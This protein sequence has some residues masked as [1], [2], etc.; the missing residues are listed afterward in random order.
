MNLGFLSR[1][2]LSRVSLGILI[3]SEICECPSPDAPDDMT[4]GMCFKRLGIPVTHSPL[5]H[6]VS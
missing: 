6:Q 1:M 2:V 4:L 3:E 5:F